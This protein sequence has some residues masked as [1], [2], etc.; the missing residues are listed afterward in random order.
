M[1]IKIAVC[2]DDELDRDS[3]L[4]GLTSI[5]EDLKLEFDIYMFASGEELC[6]NLESNTYNIILLDIIMGDFD[7]IDTA[8]KLRSMGED[9]KIIFVSSYDER[10]RDLFKVGAIA[11]IDKPVDIEELQSAIE[12][13]L[14][15]IKKEEAK[16]FAYKKQGKTCFLPL[17]KIEFFES[18]RNVVEIHSKNSSVSYTDQLK[19]IW[20]KL[21]S[22]PQFIMPNQSTIFNMQHIKMISNKIILK[23]T[24]EDF[25]IGR[26]YKADT[27]KRYGDYL[28]NRSE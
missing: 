2:D 13:G 6:E 28:K 23:S 5:E 12:S 22:Y 21:S 1:I 17:N 16:Q 18:H 24:N 4:I 7:G 15:L 9:S 3:M 11:F 25:N 10:L 19:N 26:N 14:E 8:T 20:G 27:V